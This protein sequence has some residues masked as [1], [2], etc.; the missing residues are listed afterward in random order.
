MR[1]GLKPA[2]YEVGGTA[3]IGYMLLSLK[4]NWG[5][6]FAQILFM[7]LAFYIADNAW[8]QWDLR[9]FYNN[10]NNEVLMTSAKRSYT[11]T[12]QLETGLDDKIFKRNG[13][14]YTEFWNAVSKLNCIEQFGVYA[15]ANGAVLDSA[16]ELDEL[17]AEGLLLAGDIADIC[18]IELTK[19]TAENLKAW[20]GE[21]NCPVVIGSHLAE[22]W[23]IGDCF[24][25]SLP[26]AEKPIVCEVTGIVKEGTYWPSTWFAFSQSSLTELD[27]VILI[28]CIPDSSYMLIYQLLG[29]GNFIF[30]CKNK[31]EHEA[32]EAVETLL[33]KLNFTASVQNISDMM[34]RQ[35][36]AVEDNYGSQRQLAII[37]SCVLAVYVITSMMIELAG[38]KKEMGIACACGFSVSQLHVQQLLQRLLMIIIAVMIA[39]A[40]RLAEYGE[41]IR[42]GEQGAE[43]MLASHLKDT[44]PR[45]IFLAA[46]A[47]VLPESA[48]LFIWKRN[49]T[50]ELI[51]SNRRA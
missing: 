49:T 35:E 22:Q 13:E 26:Y 39:E 8:S 45:I 34:K 37:V 3:M 25:Y 11:V 17:S 42:I 47:F 24:E 29:S 36:A 40:I 50:A 23:G 1:L 19:G 7:T 41:A 32:A 16:G 51:R 28:P 33:K 18:K 46:V 31:A 9:E 5:Y 6:I 21:G 4:K 15:A 38:R 10:R 30:E 2:L 43:I 14:I 20:D 27:D 48:A 12:S 44:L